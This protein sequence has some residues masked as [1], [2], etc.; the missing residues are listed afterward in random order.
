MDGTSSFPTGM[1]IV[2][3]GRLASMSRVSAMQV[4][5]NQGGVVR[6]RVTQRTGALVIGA[7]GWPL[8]KSGSLTRN[9][10]RASDLQDSGY[11][12]A[13]IGEA[14]FLRRVSVNDEAQPI[15]R[16]HT[17]EQISRLLG[18][19]GLRLRHWVDLGLICPTKSDSIAP[20]FDYQQV[21]AAKTLA[22]LIARGVVPRKL[23]DSLRRVQRWLSDEPSLNVSIV[24]LEKE[25]L[26]R[27]GAELIA[28]SGQLH[29][30]FDDEAYSSRLHVQ[31]PLSD[32]VD[33]DMLFDRAYFNEQQ[34]N[35]DA[36]FHDYSEWLKRYGDDHE[37][38]FNLAN[39]HFSRGDI[40]QAIRHYRRCIE[41]HPAYSRAWN[42]LG[43]CLYQSGDVSAAIPALRRSADLDPD[44]IDTLFNL[45][46]VLDEAGDSAEAKVLWLRI[47]M[48]PGVCEVSQ[49]AREQAG[50]AGS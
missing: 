34:G 31:K 27:D 23:A 1:R 50:E 16:E 35:T 11:N 15:R 18:V 37:V 22:Q 48:G 19:S 21:A 9:L 3:T 30:S 46:D 28:A 26:V 32:H 40:E 36:A 43:L 5:T 44:N 10:Q 12:I 38:L 49:Y 42:N 17:L 41:E 39:L 7:D 2:F 47:A 13:I 20:T 24:A 14:E 4:V 25:L 29:F 6:D 8:R 33:A 45:A